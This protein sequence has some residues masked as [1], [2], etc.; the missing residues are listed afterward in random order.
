[1]ILLN[2]RKTIIGSFQSCKVY[3]DMCKKN[4]EFFVIFLE[5]VFEKTTTILDIAELMAY[6]AHAIHLDFLVTMQQW[7]VYNG[8]IFL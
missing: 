5:A 3:V 1:M 7:I 8:D 4:G 6:P 2:M